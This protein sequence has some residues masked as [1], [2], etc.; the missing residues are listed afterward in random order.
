MIDW[1]VCPDMLARLSCHQVKTVFGVPTG[2]DPFLRSGK[3]LKL[4]KFLWTRNLLLN[5][6]PIKS[7]PGQ[8]LHE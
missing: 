5:L 4:M 1:E 3:L 6:Y 8:K 7:C 2:D